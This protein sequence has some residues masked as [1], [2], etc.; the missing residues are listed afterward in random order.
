MLLFKG[1]HDFRNFCKLD[2]VANQNFVRTIQ[3]ITLEEVHPD[4]APL[5]FGLFAGDDRLRLYCITIEGNAF[6]WH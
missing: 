1:E 2:V 5:T 3:N 4:G 6:L